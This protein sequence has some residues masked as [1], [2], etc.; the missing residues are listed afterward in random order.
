MMDKERREELEQE[1]KDYVDSLL[2][3]DLKKELYS[4]ESAKEIAM[5]TYIAGIASALNS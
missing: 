1:A 2:V 5:T 3:G 4:L